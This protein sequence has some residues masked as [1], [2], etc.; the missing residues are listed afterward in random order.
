LDKHIYDRIAVFS[1]ATYVFGLT[2]F[3]GGLA[4]AC[5]A[6]GCAALSNTTVTTLRG[7]LR[8]RLMR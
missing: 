2:R 7:G 5:A 3:G 4:G 1:E 6:S 8:V